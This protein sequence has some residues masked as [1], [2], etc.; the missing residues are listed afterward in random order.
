MKLIMGIL[1]LYF[2]RRLYVFRSIFNN[3]LLGVCKEKINKV[4]N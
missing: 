1:I 3:V 4:E 2:V